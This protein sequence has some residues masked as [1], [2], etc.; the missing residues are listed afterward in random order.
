MSLLSIANNMDNLK[1][2]AETFGEPYDELSATLESLKTELDKLTAENLPANAEAIKILGDQY[3]STAAQ[4]DNTKARTIDLGSMLTTLAT[5]SLVSF[6]ES[7]GGIFA[8]TANAGDLFKNLMKIV[9]DFTSNLG[10]ALIAAGIGAISFQ[11][12]MNSP[13]LAIA[14]GVALVALSAG[15]S[16]LLDKGVGGGGTGKIMSAEGTELP[17]YANGALSIAPHAAIVGDNPNARFDPELTLPVS[18]LQN[19]LSSGNEG[20]GGGIP[21]VIRLI[22]SGEDLEAVINTRQ[23]RNNNLR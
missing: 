4:I 12:L 7:L 9:L 1:K 8:G 21:A 13:G 3:K 17:G 14:A 10:K 20:N 11:K 19:Y 18:K 15:V 23:R 2:K 16:S 5:D 22:A 6:G